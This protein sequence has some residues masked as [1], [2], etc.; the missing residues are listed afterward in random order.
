VLN[1]AFPTGEADERGPK[2]VLSKVG[3][4]DDVL[5]SLRTFFKAGR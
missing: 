2:I 5:E 1:E 4:K 3:G